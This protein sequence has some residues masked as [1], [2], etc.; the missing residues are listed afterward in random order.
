MQCFSRLSLLPF[1]LQPQLYRLR[2]KSACDAWQSFSMEASVCLPYGVPQKWSGLV[3][4]QLCR[5]CWHSG[6]ALGA[7]CPSPGSEALV[8][9]S[10]PPHLLGEPLHVFRE[11]M[12][13]R[14]HHGPYCL[15]AS[16][17]CVLISD[18]PIQRGNP[19]H[20]NP[21]MAIIGQSE[22]VDPPPNRPARI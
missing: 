20:R 10:C 16:Q 22:G 15:R 1:R 18:P 14:F 13:D 8:A 17:W 2:I 19:T 6:R 21:A 7:L 11:D 3:P 12:Q 4:W 9:R 5:R